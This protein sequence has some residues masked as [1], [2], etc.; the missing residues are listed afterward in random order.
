MGLI[1]PV[2]TIGRK[3]PEEA[4]KRGQKEESRV[5]NAAHLFDVASP[6]GTETVNLALAC[7][8]DLAVLGAFEEVVPDGVLGRKDI[9]WWFSGEETRSN[10]DLEIG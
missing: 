9:Q 6:P 2:P 8:A 4:R 10:V 7:E 5:R 1:F 3:K